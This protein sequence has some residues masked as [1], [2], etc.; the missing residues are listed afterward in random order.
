MNNENEEKKEN[1]L[2]PFIVI[3]VVF[4]LWLANWLFVINF[5]PDN[6]AARGQFGDMFGASNALFSGLALAGV[7]IT[8]YLQIKELGYQRED[9]KLTRDEMKGQKEQLEH[10]VNVAKIQ[11]FETTLYN[12]ISLFRD[13]TQ[14]VS[15]NNLQGKEG[16]KSLSSAIKRKLASNPNY[17]KEEFIETMKKHG[18]RV[19]PYIQMLEAVLLFIDKSDLKENKKTGYI[20]IVTSTLSSPEIFLISKTREFH[21][22]GDNLKHFS[23]RYAI[24]KD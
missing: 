8:I 13:V 22:K 5:I 19:Y 12:L 3:V 6:H 21:P 18:W 10:Q 11:V 9:L 2:L 14:D 1:K 17:E 20:N 23:E 4:F 24:F 15:F 7:I 16:I